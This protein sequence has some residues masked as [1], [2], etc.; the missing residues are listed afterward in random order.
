[1]RLLFIHRRWS[2]Q[3]LLD[4]DADEG[5]AMLAD[6]LVMSR[7]YWRPKRGCAKRIVQVRMVLPLQVEVRKED[8]TRS[9]MVGFT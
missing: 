4:E 2:R 7:R 3:T 5:V 8:K 9:I 1:M 6:D